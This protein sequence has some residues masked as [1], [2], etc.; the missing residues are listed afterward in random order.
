MG[1][2]REMG[3]ETEKEKGEVQWLSFRIEVDGLLLRGK[4]KRKG[5]LL[6]GL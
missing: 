5:V 3:R 6:S 2:G 4:R 1:M